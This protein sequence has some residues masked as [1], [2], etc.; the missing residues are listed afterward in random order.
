MKEKGIIK[1]TVLLILPLVL[2][3]TLKSCTELNYFF[4][5]SAVETVI[6]KKVDTKN[7]RYESSGM[8]LTY[9]FLNENT[10]KTVEGSHILSYSNHSHYKIGSKV[11]IE[12]YGDG[13]FVSRIRGAPNIQLPSIL[14]FLIIYLM[15]I[16]IL[17][18]A[19]RKDSYNK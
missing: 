8:K 3:G 12:Y 1:W 5:G 6:S 17:W 19:D 14:L 4:Q 7:N 18:Y 15:V 11:T 16:L 2:L 9:M 13:I 10:K